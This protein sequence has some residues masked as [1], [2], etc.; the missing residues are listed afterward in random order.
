V[1]NLV[2]CGDGV[3]CPQEGYGDTLVEMLT[4]KRPA[5]SFRSSMRGETEL[6]TEGALHDAPALIGK[7]PDF[8][9]V[10]VGH[11]DMLRGEDPGRALGHLRELVQLLLLKTHADVAVAPL[12]TAILTAEAR[13]AAESFNARLGALA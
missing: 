11:A 10:G 13:A 12:C 7:A 5:A 4:L 2:F 6:T 9:L 1:K 8:I 3:L